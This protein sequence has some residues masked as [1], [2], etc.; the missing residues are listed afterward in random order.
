MF[1][2]DD[3]KNFTTTQKG[4]TQIIPVPV[5]EWPAVIGENLEFRQAQGKKD[6]SKYYTFMDCSMLVDSSEVRETTK[7]EKPTVRFSCI[8]DLTADGK[9]LDMGEGK[10][11]QLNRLRDCVG[12]NTPGQPWSPS[13]LIGKV[14]KVKVGHR[15]SETNPEDKFAEVEAVSPL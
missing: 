1:N 7:R 13:M 9:G 3:L 2:A 6:P 11:I 15:P 5:G 12:Q 14:L 10:N 8:L 4:S